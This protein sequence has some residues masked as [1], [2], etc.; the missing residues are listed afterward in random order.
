MFNGINTQMGCDNIKAK[1]YTYRMWIKKRNSKN[2]E[3][4]TKRKKYIRDIKSKP[5]DKRFCENYDPRTN[6]FTF[7][8]P[9]DFSFLSNPTETIKFFNSMIDI[10]T[11]QRK[12]KLN[13]YIDISNVQNLSID[14]LMYLL[15]IINNLR[16]KFRNKVFIYGNCPSD[17]NINKLF[18][19][20]GFYKFVK[21]TSI[22]PFVKDS[23]TIQ[24]VNGKNSDTEIAK[25]ISDFVSNKTGLTRTECNFIYIMMIELMSNT[26]KHAYNGSTLLYNRW[27][28]FCRY[29][30]SHSRISFTFM[31][32]GAGIPT[33]VRR[34]FAEKLDIFKIIGEHRYV[35]SA[36]D[37]KFRTATNLSYRGKGLPR[38]RQF[39]SDGKICNLR[40]ITNKADIKV[41]GAKYDAK[42]LYSSL[43]GTL[44][45]WEI[46]NKEKIGYED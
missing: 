30:Q 15:A 9:L 4:R 39:C 5:L 35:T 20:S 19:E 13:I 3:K 6:S 29:D 26:H 24:I 16:N 34:N 11:Q 33:T 18:K 17:P 10:I 31:D 25:Q 38:I 21:S 23:N 22:L 28:C 8:V 37:G 27:Y 7:P 1:C 42:E 46:I 14:A 44:Y 32:T 36:L 43:C 12:S 2:L 45:Y 41:N 40:I